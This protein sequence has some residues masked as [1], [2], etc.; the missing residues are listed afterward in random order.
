MSDELLAFVRAQRDAA[1]AVAEGHR[2]VVVPRAPRGAT[3]HDIEMGYRIMA[4]HVR[5]VMDE[6]GPRNG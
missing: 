6:A 1:I 5:R 4:A 2:A 3:E